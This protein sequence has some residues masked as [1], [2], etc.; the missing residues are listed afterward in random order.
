[1]FLLRIRLSVWLEKSRRGGGLLRISFLLKIIKGP[2]IPLVE[3]G[4]LLVEDVWID[5]N[6]A[7]GVYFVSVLIFFNLV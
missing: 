1:M 7:N 4:L 3:R 6:R 5:D 2:S